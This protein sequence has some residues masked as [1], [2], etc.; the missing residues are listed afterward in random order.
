MNRAVR[1]TLV[2]FVAL[3]GSSMAEAQ[4]PTSGNIFFGF[5][6]A[7]GEVAGRQPGMNGW[8]GSLEGKFIKWLGM[9]ADISAQYGSAVNPQLCIAPCP[10][11]SHRFTGSRYTVMFGPRVSVP[12]GNYTPFFH[13]LIGAAHESDSASLSDTSFSDAIGGGLDYRLIPALAARLQIDE[14][15]TR[16]YGFH[17]NHLRVGLGLVVRF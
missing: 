10:N 14:L 11:P 17:Q 6:H 7:Q 2:V 3:I 5:S 4:I 8:N 13:V 15:Q 1:F 9:V 16:F 12:V